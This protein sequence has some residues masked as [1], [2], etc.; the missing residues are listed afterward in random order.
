M[1]TPTKVEKLK[2]LSKGFNKQYKNVS[3]YGKGYTNIK[4]FRTGSLQLDFALGGGFPVGRIGLF[5]GD[6][7]CGKTTTALRIAGGQQNLCANCLRPVS[8]IHVDKIYD[9]ETEDLIEVNI[10]GTCDCVKTKIYESIKFPG[11]TIPN[12]SERKKLLMENSFEPF[13]VA[14]VDVEGTFDHTWSKRL[15]LDPDRILLVE[16]ETAEETIDIQDALIR[17][18]TIDFIILD[19][20]AAMAPSAEIEASTEKWQQGLGARL[21]NK[22]CRK[23]VSSTQAVKREYNKNVTQIWINQPRQKIGVMFG[24]NMTLP[25]GMHQRFAASIELKMWPSKLEKTKASAEMI[26]EFKMDIGESVRTNFR[27]DK[28]KTYTAKIQGSYRMSLRD[29]SIDDEKLIF[30]MCEKYGLIF[31]EKKKWHL[32]ENLDFDNEKLLREHLFKPEVVSQIK[33]HLLRKM[34]NREI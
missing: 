27:T 20:I 23:F 8:D 16:P 21:F 6:K 7:S 31:K 10:T 11:E 2:A 34:V 32:G 5:Y 17:S 15:G 14:V 18:G 24:D 19:S 22:A 1:S 3:K 33:N 28:N 26:D 4:R 25:Y 29:G 12:Y 13:I 9:E 30:Q